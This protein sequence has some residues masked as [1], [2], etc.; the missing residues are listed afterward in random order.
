[1]AQN[2]KY[3]ARR[4]RALASFLAFPSV[5]TAVNP[6]GSGPEDLE[7][8]SRPSV[9]APTHTPALRNGGPRQG[10]ATRMIVLGPFALRIDSS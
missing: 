7:P 2:E 9:L 8:E 1:M 10:V 5:S 6:Q 3:A 4:I